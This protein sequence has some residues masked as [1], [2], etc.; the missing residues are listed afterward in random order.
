MWITYKALPSKIVKN[1]SCQETVLIDAS[2]L[3]VVCGVI[4]STMMRIELPSWELASLV[5]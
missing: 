5:W 2:N 3:E 4:F 1:R